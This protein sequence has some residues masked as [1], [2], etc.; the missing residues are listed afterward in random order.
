[1]TRFGAAAHYAHVGVVQ[2][3]LGNALVIG[4]M[5]LFFVLALVLPFPGHHSGEDSP[6]ASTGGE[7]S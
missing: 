2:L 3:S 7:T 1:M 6:R 5:V 4:F